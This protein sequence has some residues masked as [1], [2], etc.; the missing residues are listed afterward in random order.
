MPEVTDKYIGEFRRN[1]RTEYNYNVALKDGLAE[2][3]V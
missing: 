2:L 1:I 3:A